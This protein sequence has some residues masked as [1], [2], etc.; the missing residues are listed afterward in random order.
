MTVES[1]QRFESQKIV[2]RCYPWS[3]EQETKMRSRNFRRTTSVPEKQISTSFK[4][5]KEEEEEMMREIRNVESPR[6]TM[7]LEQNNFDKE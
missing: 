3:S 6:K 5:F 2:G 1:F 4:P 7:H